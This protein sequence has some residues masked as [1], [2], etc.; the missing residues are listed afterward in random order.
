MT[1]QELSDECW[2]DLPPIRKWLAGREASDRLLA[3]A[4]R[5]FEPEQAD[6]AGYEERLLD[7]VKRRNEVRDGE[8]FAILT[9]LAI[10][11]A[12]AVISWLVQRWLDN[13][14]PKEELDA[15]RK[16]LAA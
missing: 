14:F 12:A 1:F 16:E 13:R 7:R 3:D 8:G 4:I 2:G 15:L 10:T 5:E 11:I 9:F 6:C